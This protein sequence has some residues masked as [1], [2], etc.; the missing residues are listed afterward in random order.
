[1][2]PLVILIA[3]TAS[4]PNVEPQKICQ[5]ARMAAL[6]EDQSS[7]YDSCVRDEQAAREQLQKRW[8]QFSTSARSTCA[9]PGASMTSYVEMLTCLEM[10]SGA[11]F[12][13][14]VEPLSPD[15]SP[16]PPAARTAPGAPR[17]KP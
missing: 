17:P 2:T 3:V 16:P 6:P 14:G 5:S 15:A 8:G 9:E 12:G 4:M 10:Q 1:M 11:D 7:A 13:T